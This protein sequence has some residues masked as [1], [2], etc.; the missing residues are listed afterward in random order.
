[1]QISCFF[2]NLSFVEKLK[3]ANYYM[4]LRAKGKF[5]IL[6]LLESKGIDIVDRCTIK[7]N[8][9]KR[10]IARDLEQAQYE[11]LKIDGSKENPFNQKGVLEAVASLYRSAGLV[12]IL[13]V[14]KC[15][16]LKGEIIKEVE[17]AEDETFFSL[18]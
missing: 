12:D 18:K 5:Q 14:E 9:F 11:S 2:K 8:T 17:R 10:A 15:K 3:S 7:R 13:S 1:M 4:C 16:K 6:R